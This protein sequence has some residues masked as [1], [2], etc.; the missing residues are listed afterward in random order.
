M[1][2]TIHYILSTRRRLNLDAIKKW[3]A[4]LRARAI[5]LEFEHVGEWMEIGPDYP[6]AYHWPRGARKAADLLPPVEGWMFHATPGDGVETVR[7][8]LCRFAGIPGWRLE[9]FCKTQ[10]ASRHGWEHFLKCHRGVTE[11]LRAAESLGIQVKAEDEGKLWETGS[12][13]V[14]RRN[15]EEYDQC[16]AAFCGALTDADESGTGVVSPISDHPQFE[17]LEAE[18]LAG[19]GAEIAGAVRLVKRMAA[20]RR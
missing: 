17:R 1:G 10:Y 9:S 14:L 18:G 7:M 20:S 8:G 3:L 4:P 19:R 6:G 11:L 16:I 13:R 5:V 15:L 12:H 2:L